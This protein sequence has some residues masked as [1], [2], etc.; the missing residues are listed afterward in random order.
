MAASLQDSLGIRSSAPS[1]FDLAHIRNTM[2]L[3]GRGP[4]AVILGLA[5]GGI[6]ALVFRQ[7]EAMA[8]ELGGP[9]SFDEARLA[10]NIELNEQT[11]RQIGGDLAFEAGLSVIGIGLIKQIGHLLLSGEDGAQRFS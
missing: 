1:A 11:L 7:Q 6:V 10:L 3:I 9:V 2:G 5:V 4:S 8:A